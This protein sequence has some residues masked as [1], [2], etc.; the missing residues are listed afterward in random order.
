MEF[1]R[2]ARAVA[3]A[4]HRPALV[5]MAVLIGFPLLLFGLA[6]VLDRYPSGL[7]HFEVRRVPRRQ[8]RL[9]KLMA[10][11]RQAFQKPSV[12]RDCE[13]CRKPTL[14]R[15]RSP[16]AEGQFAYGSVLLKTSTCSRRR[17]SGSCS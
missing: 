8:L 13:S 6:M 17:A 12:R 7:G 16:S 5:A 2:A 3:A 14:D 9:H 11:C 4:T 1:A 10:R 15:A